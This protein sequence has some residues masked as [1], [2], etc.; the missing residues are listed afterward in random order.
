MTP[1]LEDELRL[2]IEFKDGA[3]EALKKALMHRKEQE[4]GGETAVGI[5][6]MNYL[7]DNY[8]I[9]VKI[10]F[11]W[12][13]TPKRGVKP[14][15][16]R[17][18]GWLTKT[19][20][21][22]ERD[23]IALCCLSTLT[24]VLSSTVNT[25][26]H[27]DVTLST[28]ASKIG[29]NIIEEARLQEFLNSHDEEVNQALLKGIKERR[30]DYYRSYYAQYIMKQ[31]DWIGTSWGGEDESSLGAKLVEVLLASTDFF[32]EWT[33]NDAKGKTM[34]EIHG[35]QAFIDTWSKNEERLLNLAFQTCPMIIPPQ[36]WTAFDEG[37]YYGVL[38]PNSNLLRLPS[39]QRG[40]KM[41]IFTR[42]YMHKLNQ[43]DISKVMMA[44]NAIQKTPWKIDKK[45]LAVA[46][47]LVEKGG[48]KA[49]LPRMNPF[50][51]LPRLQNPTEEELKAQKKRL[52]A[53]YK[54]EASRKGQAIRVLA[55]LRIAERFKDYDKIY[56]PCNMDFRGRVYPIPSFSFQGDDLNKGLIQFADTP[57]V[58]S[59]N[60]IYWFMVAGAEFAGIDKVP[61]DECIQWVK[62]HEEHIYASAEDPIG[63]DWWM[64]WDCP[65]E[66]L[67][68]CFEYKALKEYR[69]AHNGSAIGWT[70]GVPVAFDGSCSGLQH[71]SAL[72]R[73]PQGAEAVNL[74]PADRPQDIY[75]RVADLVC[76][77]MKIDA[78]SGTSDGWD[79]KKNK[80]KYGTKTLAQLWLNYGNG[81]VNRK[82][83][84]RSVMTLAY[85]S[86]EYGFRDQIFEDTV[87]P[88]MGEGI[89]T[90][91]N[92]GQMAGYMAHLIWQNIGKVVVK[93]VEGMA[94]LQKAA[95]LVCKTG[96]VVTWVTPMGLPVQQPY[97]TVSS[98]VY[99]MRFAK[100]EKRFYY[101]KVTGDVDWR[102]QASGIAPNFIHSMDASHLQYSVYTAHKQGI[103][104]FAMIHDSYGTSIEQADQLFH[105]IRECFVDMYEKHDVLKEFAEEVQAFVN[106]DLPERPV[107]G[108]FEVRQVL[109]S[110]YAFH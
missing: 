90:W 43:V 11:E 4:E 21:G 26:V 22:Q 7:Y 73:D 88:N 62:D 42:Q 19:Y 54:K 93:A 34:T 74:K 87:K 89:F 3:K 76:K 69:D 1:T 32:S 107:K 29:R 83:C 52:I 55:N 20:K 49:G 9:N 96:N 72:L 50:D 106:D 84:K 77:Q 27:K 58:T 80:M 102:K 95:K 64:Q 12:A 45:V 68:F 99:R 15:Y 85:G 10:W 53:L 59:E 30:S 70:T 65:W 40:G 108:N 18:L 71:F 79:E 66:F 33:V 75:Q 98:E 6:V 92:G 46:Q 37:G 82:T 25:S 104:H 61:F 60:A 35:T 24:T 57:P 94:W 47:A 17:V 41:D 13:T 109:D 91:E 48:E 28:I 38:Q 81:S 23:L 101:V 86:K 105:V 110:L 51:P 39:Y 16:T 8:A 31:L 56:F 97:L 67:Q 36:D 14:R 100:T 2:E 44:V 103:T 78:V 63:Y 5:R